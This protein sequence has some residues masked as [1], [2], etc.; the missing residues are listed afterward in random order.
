[1]IITLVTF[2]KNSHVDGAFPKSPLLSPTIVMLSIACL[3]VTADVVTLGVHFCHGKTAAM[4]ERMVQRIRTVLSI[5]QAI[6]GATSAGYFKSA[7]SLSNGAD[8]WGFCCSDAATANFAD[9]ICQSNVCCAFSPLPITYISKS[10]TNSC[11]WLV[12]CVGAECPTGHRASSIICNGAL[13]A[14]QARSGPQHK[15]GR[16]K[17]LAKQG[18]HRR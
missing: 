15:P 12:R 13:D 10:S 11:P 18:R 16:S 4:A 1:M 8:I 7:Q 17:T 14:V 6:G 3:N 9:M 2:N 5:I